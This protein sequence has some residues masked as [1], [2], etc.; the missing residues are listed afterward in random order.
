M[1]ANSEMK[2]EGEEVSFR[3]L[4]CQGKLRESRA[5]VFTKEPKILFPLKTLPW[6]LELQRKTIQASKHS[7]LKK[8]VV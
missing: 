7:T 1:G 6:D 4:L 2:E 3:E 5:Q 8:A